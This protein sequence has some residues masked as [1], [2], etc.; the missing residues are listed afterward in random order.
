VGP[1][2]AQGPTGPTGAAGADGADGLDGVDGA[3]HLDVVADNSEGT[4]PDSVWINNA[5]IAEHGESPRIYDTATITAG[6]S[7]GVTQYR[8]LGPDPTLLSSYHVMSRVSSGILT[9]INDEDLYTPVI[10]DTKAISDIVATA[11]STVDQA[12]YLTS[13]IAPSEYQ[14][15]TISG[16]EV[17]SAADLNCTIELR[18]S[19]SI[20]YGA[21]KFRKTVIAKGPASV[22][23]PMELLINGLEDSNM[24]IRVINNGTGTATLRTS[25]EHE[26]SGFPSATTESVARLTW[27]GR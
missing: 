9:K 11:G 26:E 21:L 15:L 1:T 14:S 16:L 7:L 22:D 24:I 2:G 25:I 17:Y 8:Y 13:N 12:L 20:D 10:K 4:L 5:Y 19:T 27:S 18:G 6:S 23:V 3:R